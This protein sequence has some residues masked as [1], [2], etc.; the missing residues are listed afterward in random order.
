MRGVAWRA[1]YVGGAFGLWMVLGWLV[2]GAD[3]GGRQPPDLLALLTCALLLLAPALTFGPLAR[4]WPAPLY[5]LEAII[6]WGT[7]GYVFVFLAPRDS[8]SRAEFMLF[9][10]PLTVALATLFT[11][12][13]YLAGLRVYRGDPRRHDFVRAR[14]QGYLA[15]LFVV[16]LGLLNTIGV[17]T[18]ANGALLLLICVLTESLMLARRAPASGARQARRATRLAWPLGRNAR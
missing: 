16:T 6:G 4:C 9:V 7:F 8:L 10:L 18:A 14:R 1:V 17:L 3:A 2:F 13:A 12:V 5:D 11:L 15:A